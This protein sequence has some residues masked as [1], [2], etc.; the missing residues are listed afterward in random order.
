[1]SSFLYGRMQA[2]REDAK[3]RNASKVDQPPGLKTYADILV[4]LVPAEVLAAALF[5]VSQF[6]STRAK[7][8]PARTS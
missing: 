4:G 2:Q 3:T 1:M 7:T 8:L 6:S 5:F